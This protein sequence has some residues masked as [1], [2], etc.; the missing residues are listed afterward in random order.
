MPSEVDKRIGQTLPNTKI[1]ISIDI[2]R[3]NKI[4]PMGTRAE[5]GIARK[6]SV[7]GDRLR[8]VRSER[9]SSVPKL[10]PA[11]SA[12]EKPTSKVMT[13]GTKSLMKW[14]KSQVSANVISI[15]SSD[16]K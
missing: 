1:G 15:R 4:K 6:N 10:T 12:I 13:L 2:P 7:N 14:V 9:P 16:G 5:A 3:P 11:M 8:R